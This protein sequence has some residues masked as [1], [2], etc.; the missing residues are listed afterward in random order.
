MRRRHL[1]AGGLA[2]ACGSLRARGFAAAQ[3]K[4]L[5]VVAYVSIGHPDGRAA[6][7]F[8]AHRTVQDGGLVSMAPTSRRWPRQ[9]ASYLDRIMRGA[10]PSDL[11]VELPKT[12]RDVC[13]PNTARALGLEVP[14]S[15]LAT[16]D[17]VI[18]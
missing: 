12:L 13:E 6:P 8:P 11:P 10:R 3:S 14:T 9:G 16:A 4:R 5:P 18:E 17:V 2:A 7:Y 15:P 1:L